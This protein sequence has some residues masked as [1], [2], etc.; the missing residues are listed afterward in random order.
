MRELERCVAEA[1]DAGNA[2]HVVFGERLRQGTLRL[3]QCK[4]AAARGEMRFGSPS[5]LGGGGGLSSGFS[6]APSNRDFSH[7]SP[8]PQKESPMERTLRKQALAAKL[9]SNR[10]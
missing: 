8:S 7:R 6:P 5:V 2:G 9:A 10:K 4:A 1:R 3:D